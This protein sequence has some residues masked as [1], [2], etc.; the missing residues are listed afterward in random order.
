[1]S[2]VEGSKPEQQ[3][4]HP[5]K[6][7]WGNLWLVPMILILVGIA[8]VAIRRQQ[9][10]GYFIVGNTV[11]ELDASFTGDPADTGAKRTHAKRMARLRI[12]EEVKRE[13]V[14][15]SVDNLKRSDFSALFTPEIS[16]PIWSIRPFTPVMWRTTIAKDP[17]IQK[18]LR[19]AESGTGAERLFLATL[20]E[21]EWQ[22]HGF[23]TKHRPKSHSVMGGSPSMG[24]PLLF[25]ALDRNGEYLGIL[26]EMAER[27][28][29]EEPIFSGWIPLTSGHGPLDS[30]VS[31]LACA[32]ECIL[33]NI[34]PEQFTSRDLEEYMLLRSKLSE[35]ALTKL[36]PATPSTEEYIQVVWGDHPL[37]HPLPVIET[38]L[39]CPIETIVQNLPAW[40]EP[41]VIKGG[42]IYAGETTFQTLDQINLEWF[43]LAVAHRINEARVG[44]LTGERP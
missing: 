19:I 42:M 1:M 5:H 3:P 43:V 16:D 7:K 9:A 41:R 35:L 44:Q 37:E 20:L 17:R 6:S 10:A 23:G 36:S 38:W 21:H 29:H 4:I 12:L 32:T 33:A 24:L 13:G 31:V 25:A 15:E 18:L 34:D 11:V 14:A 27:Y 2:Q 8:Y 26:L 39:F 28:I 40:Y 22:T 30:F